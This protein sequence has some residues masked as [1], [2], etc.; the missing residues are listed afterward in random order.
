[1]NGQDELGR[2]MTGHMPP[3][4]NSGSGPGWR[5]LWWRMINDALR[6]NVP[7]A[8][9]QKLTAEFDKRSVAESPAELTLALSAEVERLVETAR[10]GAA[11]DV[12][13]LSEAVAENSVGSPGAST[14]LTQKAAAS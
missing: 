6:G 2:S 9:V 10:G 8:Q 12:Q 11:P 4:E 5:R 1:M 14:P 3:F 7:L 13:A